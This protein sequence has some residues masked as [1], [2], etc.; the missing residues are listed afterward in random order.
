MAKKKLSEL[1]LLLKK[2]SVLVDAKYATKAEA[3]ADFASVAEG[4]AAISELT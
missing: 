4:K 3:G 2:L 1:A